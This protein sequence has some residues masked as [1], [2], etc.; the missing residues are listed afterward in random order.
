MNTI[1]SCEAPIHSVLGSVLD[2][3]RQKGE[4]YESV[5]SEKETERLFRVIGERFLP[6]KVLRYGT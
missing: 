2:L 4:S 3:K 5:L 1:T 6:H